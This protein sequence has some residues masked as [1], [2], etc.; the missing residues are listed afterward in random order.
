MT[1]AE[2]KE[3]RKRGR[4]ERAKLG[5]KFATSLEELADLENVD[6]HLRARRGRYVQRLEELADNGDVSMQRFALGRLIDLSDEA[7]PSRR[8]GLARRDPILPAIPTSSPLDQIT[9]TRDAP[10]FSKVPQELLEALERGD[11][12]TIVQKTSGAKRKPPAVEPENEEPNE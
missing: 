3:S 11:A 8:A 9:D 2:K 7:A 4:A 6:E 5:Y 1:E 12:V 10:D